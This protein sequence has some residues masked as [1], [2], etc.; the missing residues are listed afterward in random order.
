MLICQ[1][2][3]F[4]IRARERN[5]EKAF[6]LNNIKSANFQINVSPEA[7]VNAMTLLNRYQLR[8]KQLILHEALKNNPADRL[9]GIKKCI[10]RQRRCILHESVRL[11]T[12]DELTFHLSSVPNHFESI[13]IN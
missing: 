7:I 10:L 5:R 9:L 2:F 1:G 12:E 4:E 3:F 11:K 8:A 6:D 13:L